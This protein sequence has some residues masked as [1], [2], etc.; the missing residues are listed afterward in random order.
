MAGNTFGLPAPTIE[1][2]IETFILATL[3]VENTGKQSKSV[4]FP[5][6]GFGWSGRPDPLL[7]TV[8]IMEN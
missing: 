7:T 1:I 8:K 3:V 4:V 6:L 2:H 5:M